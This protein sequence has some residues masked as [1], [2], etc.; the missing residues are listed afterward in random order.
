M[1]NMLHACGAIYGLY[2]GCMPIELASLLK[3]YRPSTTDGR[4]VKMTSTKGVTII[5]DY[6]HEKNSLRAVAKLGRSL[7][8]RGGR[9]TGVVRLNH[10]RPDDVLYHFGE[11]AGDLFDDIV[12]YDKIDG[13]WRRAQE[14][15]MKRFPREVGRTSLLVAE[16]ASRTNKFVERIVREDQAVAYAARHAKAGDVVV[17][18]IND[19]VKRSL[20]FIKENFSIEPV[21]HERAVQDTERGGR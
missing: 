19:D 17:V 4:L 12:V 13:Y 1:W 2:D 7:V 11:L 15:D 16:G 14:T 20:G 5:A 9:L 8:K 3:S 21:D 6:A 18:I 10:E